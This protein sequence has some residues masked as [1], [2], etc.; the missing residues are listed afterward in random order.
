VKPNW[1]TAAWYAWQW[2]VFKH[3]QK[4][5]AACC[6]VQPATVCIAIASFIVGHGVDLG[7][8][9]ND[10]RRELAIRALDKFINAG[11]YLEPPNPLAY[12]DVKAH[13]AARREHAMMLRCEGWKWKQIAERFGISAMR[14][15]QL[16]LSGGVELRR[17]MSRTKW[18][19]ID[20]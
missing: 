15:K 10:A 13:S 19:W 14:A 5:I 17:A 2:A 11:G 9:Y 20:G 6:N 4:E 7:Y 16:A 18:T 8:A 1:N 12:L 3:S